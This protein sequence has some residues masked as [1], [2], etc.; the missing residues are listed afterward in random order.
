MSQ[1]IDKK[2]CQSCGMP[3]R[4]DVE[5]YLGTN[6][7]HS[8]SDEYCYYCLKD[9]EYTVDIP[10]EQMV[11]IWIKYTDKYNWYSGTNYTPQELRALLNKRLPTLKR[12]QQKEETQTIHYT[13][14]NQ[15]KTYIDQNLF[16]ELNPKQLAETIN[17]SFFHFRKVFRNVT[18]ENIGAYIQRLRLEY[19]AHLLVAT[20]E[21]LEDIL[22]QTNY[23]TNSSLAK[24]FK[25]HFGT[26]MLAYRTK[27]SSVKNLS[28]PNNLP[29]VQIKRINT[30]KNICIEVGNNF[31]DKQA[32]KTIWEQLILYKKNHLPVNS[33]N[34]FISISLDN[35]QITSISKCRFF[36]G[37]S[38]EKNI[39]TLGKF[40]LQEIPGGM[41]AIFRHKGC[42]SLLPKL[43]QTIYEQ[44][45][46]QSGY[47][48]KHPLTFEVYLNTP[49]DAA[50]DNLLTDIYIPIDK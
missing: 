2:Y 31:H 1:T 43:Y 14:I 12:W 38:I 50:I 44:W 15:I 45:L 29:D 46:P 13:A 20:D 28:T 4:F 23:L 8:L 34:H 42:Y 17:L 21:S 36:I 16:S 37:I 11:D 33:T 48:Q 5:E 35:P 47:I 27:H 6:A 9:G 41:Y 3:L 10:M 40:S 30:Q 26:S 39:K 24:A 25:K 7:D 22:K 19:I 49:R 18:K 32:Y